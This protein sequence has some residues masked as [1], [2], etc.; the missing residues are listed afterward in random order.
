VSGAKLLLK[1]LCALP[2]VATAF[3]LPPTSATAQDCP[4]CI[5]GGEYGGGGGLGDC[6]FTSLQQCQATASGQL[7]YCDAN[8]YFNA[9]SDGRSGFNATSDGQPG[10]PHQSRRKF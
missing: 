4:F 10:R 2:V 6:S 9:T 3:A 1:A 7:A 5:K 8:P